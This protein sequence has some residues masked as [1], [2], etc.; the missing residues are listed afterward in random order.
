LQK[1][2][3]FFNRFECKDTKKPRRYEDRG[4]VTVMKRKKYLV[5]VFQQINFYVNTVFFSIGIGLLK[6]ET[7]ILHLYFEEK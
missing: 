1:K 3:N 2:N 4:N 5:I 6:T 7:L